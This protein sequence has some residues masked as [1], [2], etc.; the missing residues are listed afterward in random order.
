MPRMY[1]S[2]PKFSQTPSAIREDVPVYRL[3]EDCFFDDTH[4]LAGSVLETTEDFEP[5]VAMFPLNKLAYEKL[6]AFLAGCDVKGKEWSEKEKKAYV[7]QLV[8]FEREWAKINGIAASKRVHLSVAAET[9]GPILGAPTDKRS[10]AQVDMTSIPQV[11]FEDGTA[12]GKGNTM[13]KEMNSAKAVRASTA[14]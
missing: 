13:D 2:P 3:R 5:N 12:I 10:V 9:K 8:A 14:A 7:P 4:W 11:P 6:T 1:T